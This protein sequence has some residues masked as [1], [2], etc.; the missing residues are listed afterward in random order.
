M[1]AAQE[2]REKYAA[3]IEAGEFRA[4]AEANKICE[5]CAGEHQTRHCPNAE[6]YIAQCEASPPPTIRPLQ[7]WLE[8][9]RAILLIRSVVD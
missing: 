3:A 8:L 5:L 9:R 2:I 6:I 7:R 4:R 1:S